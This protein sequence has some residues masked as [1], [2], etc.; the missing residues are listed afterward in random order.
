MIIFLLFLPF[1]CYGEA[2]SGHSMWGCEF[3]V[4]ESRSGLLSFS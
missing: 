3:N 2:V 1:L 4:E